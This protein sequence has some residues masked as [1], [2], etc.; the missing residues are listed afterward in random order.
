[1]GS[2]ESQFRKDRKMLSRRK[3]DDKD[4]VGRTYRLRN[5]Q[6]TETLFLKM[7]R[8]WGERRP[9]VIKDKIP[10]PDNRE[11]RIFGA[12]QSSIQESYLCKSLPE[13]RMT[14][15]Q[16]SSSDQPIYELASG[17]SPLTI[18]DVIARMQ[19]ID[20]L[21]PATDGLKWFNR[22]YSM[23]TQQVDF[24][25]PNGEWQSPVWFNRLDVVFANFYFDAIANFLAGRPVP[26]AWK[27]LLEARF[28]T[29]IDRIQ[30]ALAGMNAHINHDLAL[31]LMAVDAELNIVPS[32]NG[33]EFAD[34]QSVNGLLNTVM[35]AALTMLATDTL[36]GLAQDTG[37]IGRLLA[38]WNICS[39][40][41][42]AWEFADHLRALVGPSRDAALSTQG[43]LTGALSRAILAAA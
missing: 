15:T 5:N 21:L 19:A 14:A 10:K 4:K 18:G 32:R 37:K 40:R 9:N 24:H 35:P 1:M 29:G 26:A 39:A 36:G 27:V 6:S 34:Y 38:F 3:S 7:A 33:L 25:P 43:A 17:A 41:D 22:L 23:V 13:T 11:N 20:S 2:Q 28:D 8:Q 42:V 12:R 31:A 16:I 30:F